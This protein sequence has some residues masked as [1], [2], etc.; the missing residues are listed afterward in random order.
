MAAIADGEAIAKAVLA[1]QGGGGAL[2]GQFFTGPVGD[3]TAWV[4]TSPDGLRA[5]M[6]LKIE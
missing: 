6:K 4:S 5:N 1:R 2:G 3:L